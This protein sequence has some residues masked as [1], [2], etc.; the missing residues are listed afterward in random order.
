MGAGTRREP[1]L[2]RTGFR[3]HGKAYAGALL[4]QDVPHLRRE[5]DVRRFRR[6][7]TEQHAARQFPRER[8]ALHIPPRRR[9]AGKGQRH[10]PRHQRNDIHAV[11]QRHS[12]RQGADRHRSGLLPPASRGRAV[13]RQHGRQD[14]RHRRKRRERSPSHGNRH[15]HTDNVEHPLRILPA[16]RFRS[17][18]TVQV[19]PRY[20]C[21]AGGDAVRRRGVP[22]G[23]GGGR[24]TMAVLQKR[25]PRTFRPYFGEFRLLL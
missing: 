3:Q 5:H 25:R 7:R 17:G 8:Q 11:R 9:T 23:E 15:G 13:H 20:G 14:N 4:R 19:F 22:H 24:G 10:I 12:Q 1:V 6:S 2:R 16:N 18:R 21:R